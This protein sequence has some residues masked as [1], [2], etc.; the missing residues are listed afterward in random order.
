[1]CQLA[2]TSPFLTGYTDINV[3]SGRKYFYKVNAF[4]WQV[5]SPMSNQVE[6]DF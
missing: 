1:M 6:I 3:I 4:N 5:Q 2:W